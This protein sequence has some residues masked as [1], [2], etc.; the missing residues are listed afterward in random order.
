MR[1]VNFGVSQSK[2]RTPLSSRVLN[3][4]A[5]SACFV[6]AL[7]YSIGVLAFPL[8]CVFTPSRLLE[9]CGLFVG[10]VSFGILV[11]RGIVLRTPVSWLLSV[12]WLA[13]LGVAVVHYIERSFL[14][15]NS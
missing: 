8:D 3:I 6:A 5:L 14:C 2:V 9:I 15:F 4:A 1:R 10:L 7:S 12:V 13:M 11:A